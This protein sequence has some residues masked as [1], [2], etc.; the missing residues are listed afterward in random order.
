MNTKWKSTVEVE[1]TTDPPP[2]YNVGDRVMYRD[3]PD[4]V[5]TVL[6][7]NQGVSC[8]WARASQHSVNQSFPAGVFSL[9]PR[10]KAK[11]PSPLI[12]RVPVKPIEQPKISVEKKPPDRIADL[13]AEATDVDQCWTIAKMAGADVESL[14]TKIGHLSNGLQRMGLGNHL[15][16]MWKSGQFDPTSIHWTSKGFVKT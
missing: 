5:W 14:R 4:N 6:A 12:E 15:R 10:K 3:D 16:K 11:A 8:W 1:L 9:D 13:L 7:I 2:S